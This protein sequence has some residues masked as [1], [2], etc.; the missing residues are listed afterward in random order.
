MNKQQ[1]TQLASLRKKLL[2]A[3]A[4]LLVACIMT[5]SSTYAWFTL[6]TAPEV[7]GISTTIGANGNLEMA[8]G[9]YDTVFGTEDPSAYVGSS[10]DVTGNWTETNITW[11]NLVDLS[12]G[13]GLDMVKLMPSRLTFVGGA[14]QQR[15]AH[16]YAEKQDAACIPVA[17][18]QESIHSGHGAAVDNQ[19]RHH[20]DAHKI[21]DRIEYTGFF[22]QHGI[23]PIL[24]GQTVESV[25][26]VSG[27]PDTPE[28]DGYQQQ[29]AG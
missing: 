2:A 28:A 13:Y 10:F 17:C 29:N 3:V 26:P 12:E 11:G 20:M 7:K 16:G 19:G 8:L 23:A 21:D 5:V 18:V 24:V 25:G 1:S 14:L 27:Q 15:S 4:M 22:L 9:T 6:S